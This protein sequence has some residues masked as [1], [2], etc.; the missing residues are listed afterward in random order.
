MNNSIS[1]PIYINSMTDYYNLLNNELFEN[2][3][4]LAE[5]L[6]KNN[7]IPSISSLFQ[8]TLNTIAWMSS[9][10]NSYTVQS[11]YIDWQKYYDIEK[12]NL[13]N[14]KEKKIVLN[15]LEEEFW[16]DLLSIGVFWSYIT[17]DDWE[18]SDYDLVVVLDHYEDSDIYEREK[19]SPKFK[20]RLKEAWVDSLFAFNFSTLE[21]LENASRTNPLLLE[22]MW[23][24]F[25]TLKDNLHKLEDIFTTD[26]WIKYLGNF[27]WQWDLL[28]TTVNLDRIDF[29]LNEYIKISALATEHWHI[30]I[31]LYYK[32]E[33]KKLEITKEILEREAV[34]IGRFDFDFIC[35]DL[36]NLNNEKLDELFELY[37]NASIHWTNSIQSYESVEN[38]IRFS[39]IL[40]ENN[41]ILS[42]LQH[43]YFALR[44]MLSKLLHKT[45]NFIIDWEFTQKFLQVFWENLPES[46]INI[47]YNDIFKTEQILWRTWYISFDL[48]PDGSYIFEQW[49]YDY[50]SLISQFDEAIEYFQS[51]WNDLLEATWEVETVVS[52]LSNNESVT[53]PDFIFPNEL[54]VYNKSDI[55]KWNINEWLLSSKYIFVIN[56]HDVFPPD[57]LLK[58]LW[59]FNIKNTMC[60]SWNRSSKVRWV[61]NKFHNFVF[62]NKNF[63]EFWNN[64]FNDSPRNVWTTYFTG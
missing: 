58:L 27:V 24:S 5:S 21:E 29:V 17:K 59:G 33:I 48:N 14:Q 49:D 15:L 36:L 42:S 8:S 40:K 60:V 41:V 50:E 12:R 47:F 52:I 28:N 51:N 3:I 61:K 2:Q 23:K 9:H 20:K 19:I 26:R 53:I 7:I 54:A 62:E 64:I 44:N 31:N 4:F 35:K 1:S 63:Q 39:E 13:I 18:Y 10:E 56:S 22:T 11:L 38:N 45:W 46:I 16:N 25:F 32:W 37:K 55:E 43:R 6:L 57:Y 34:F 30:D